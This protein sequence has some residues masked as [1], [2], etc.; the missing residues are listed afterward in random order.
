M[1]LLGRRVAREGGGALDTDG[2]V[3]W[4]GRFIMKDDDAQF[5]ALIESYDQVQDHVGMATFRARD[6]QKPCSARRS[7][8]TRSTVA[9]AAIPESRR[10]GSG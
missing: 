2:L 5:A 1:E 3:G 6:A 4:P 9:S 10:V 7:M 8:F